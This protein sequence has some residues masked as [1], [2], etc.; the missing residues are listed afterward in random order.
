MFVVA[1]SAQ[2]HARVS[3]SR[4]ASGRKLNEVAD[5]VLDHHAPAGDAAVWIAG[6]ETPV[7]PLSSVTSCTVVNLIKAEVAHRLTEAGAPPKVLTAACHL[8]ADRAR[9]GFE[10]TYDDYRRRIGV[11]YA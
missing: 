6:L 8:G 7:A 1:L 11:L 2:A 10:A 3:D 9:A 5:L 4:H